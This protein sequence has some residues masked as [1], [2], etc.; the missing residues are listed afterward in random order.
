MISTPV[1][2][3]IF[4]MLAWKAFPALQTGD[5]VAALLGISVTHIS[6]ATRSFNSMICYSIAFVCANFVSYTVNAVWVFESG[7]HRRL[8]EIGLF[9]I[10]SGATLVI[11]TSLIGTVIRYLGVHTSYVFF[12][13]ILITPIPN[14]WIRKFFIFKG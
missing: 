2:I 1:K 11:T 7:R 14:C 3:F 12:F 8:V 9:L 5:P 4:Y 6:I 13:T 10:S